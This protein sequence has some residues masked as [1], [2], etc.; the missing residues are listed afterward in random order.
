MSEFQVTCRVRMAKK[1]PVDDD[2]KTVKTVFD[3]AVEVRRGKVKNVRLTE[4]APRQVIVKA[5]VS[6]KTESEALSV[7]WNLVHRSHQARQ[8]LI[9]ST[10]PVE[11]K[12]ARPQS[13][14]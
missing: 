4:V 8:G 11:A 14:A 1:A 3:A 9:H 12:P 7:V 5:R 6:A 2:K 13:R 10:S